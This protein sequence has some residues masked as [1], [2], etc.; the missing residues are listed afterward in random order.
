MF[1][2]TGLAA[3]LWVPFW[4]LLAPRSRQSRPRQIETAE[5]PQQWPWAAVLFSPAFWAISA[6]V[7]FFS[8]YWYFLL[9]WMPAYLTL[10]RGFSTMG[11]GRIFS[12]PLF[13]M[14]VVNVGIGW[15]ADRVA[16][17]SE[18]VFRTRILFAAAGLVGASSILLLNVLPGRTPVLPIL[19]ISICSFG[20]TSSSYW[21]MAQHIPPSV[22]AGRTIGYLN[23][24]SQVA[25]AVAPVITGWSLGPAKNFQFA[26]SLA[27]ITP[28]IACILLFI[29]GPRGLDQ[30]KRILAVAELERKN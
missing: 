21:A 22:L 11:M 13:I 18:A 29:A 7:F 19:V 14:A 2:V 16:T 17:R 6:C 24:L 9:T 30:L 28:L 20:V 27:G 4:I 8:Y 1:A 3:F 10:S 5:A 15:L 26:I 25:G 12:M 23:T